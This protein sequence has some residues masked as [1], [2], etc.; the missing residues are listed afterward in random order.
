MCIWG[1]SFEAAASKL[2]RHGPRTPIYAH[3]RRWLTLCE[4]ISIAQPILIEAAPVLNK[5]IYFGR[6][7]E[8]V[9]S[10]LVERGPP[11][12]HPPIAGDLVGF[13]LHIS[14]LTSENRNP[15]GIKNLNG[16]VLVFYC[17]W[18]HRLI[19]CGK[20]NAATSPRAAARSWTI[21]ICLFRSPLAEHLK[22]HCWHSK[23]FTLS[24]TC[25][26][27]PLKRSFVEH[28]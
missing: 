21:L 13:F 26:I 11:S 27:C 4:F 16:T 25:L 28:L 19:A 24:C 3:L 23:S 1:P 12:P 15:T 22:L 9:T 14:K 17:L 5:N 10:K 2:I 8:A 18:W 6:S 7:F 20:S